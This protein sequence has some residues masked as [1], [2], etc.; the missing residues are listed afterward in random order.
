ML[1][2]SVLFEPPD[3]WIPRSKVLVPASKRL[4]LFR[5]ELIQGKV[6]AVRLGAKAPAQNRA[7]SAQNQTKHI[8]WLERQGGQGKG[9]IS[10]CPKPAVA[11]ANLTSGAIHSQWRCPTGL[12]MA[13]CC[14]QTASGD[15]GQKQDGSLRSSLPRLYVFTGR[16]VDLKPHTWRSQW[17]RQG[18]QAVVL[19]LY[20]LPLSESHCCTCAFTFGKPRRL[21]CLCNQRSSASS[22]LTLH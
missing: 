1:P 13:R 6:Q 10:A 11:L 3:H 8:L 22:E 2:G 18:K 7:A 17:G 5:G 20:D 12:S 19:L 16:H 14:G 4:D 9:G 21:R 15:V